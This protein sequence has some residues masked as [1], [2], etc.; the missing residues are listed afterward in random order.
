MNALWFALFGV[1]P[2]IV[3]AGNA[4]LRELRGAGE[5]FGTDRADVQ[6]ALREGNFNSTFA[7]GLVDSAVGAVPYAEVTIHA[8]RVDA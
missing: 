2:W 8:G 5:C 1:D 4:V 7:K 3:P 6:V